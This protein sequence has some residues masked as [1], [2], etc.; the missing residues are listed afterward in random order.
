MRSI[1]WPTSTISRMKRAQAPLKSKDNYNQALSYNPMN[2][3]GLS[4]PG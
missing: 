2:Y 3:R 1:A 4:I